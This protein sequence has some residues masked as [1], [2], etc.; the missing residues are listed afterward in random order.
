[1]EICYNT[2]FTASVSSV[3]AESHPRFV[4]NTATF[5]YRA[6]ISTLRNNTRLLS[7]VITLYNEKL[8]VQQTKGKCSETQC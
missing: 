5:H 4:A 2:I 7:A 1:M 8:T 3:R 6:V